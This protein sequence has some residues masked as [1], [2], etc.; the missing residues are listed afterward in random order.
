MPSYQTD[1]TDTANAYNS[2]NDDEISDLVQKT[3]HV[4]DQVNG[5]TLDD[6]F[7]TIAAHEHPDK[8]FAFAYAPTR[9][10]HAFHAYLDPDDQTVTAARSD[11]TTE[12]TTFNDLYS[13]DER[14]SKPCKTAMNQ[15][16]VT[17]E[18]RQQAEQDDTPSFAHVTYQS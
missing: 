7:R 1:R 5:K 2:L 17:T 15:N 8:E 18:L 12:T 11:Y 13:W 4:A 9:H 6:A 16:M 10:G 14:N 3:R